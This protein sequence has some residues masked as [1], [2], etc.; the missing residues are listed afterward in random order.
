[1]T[2]KAFKHCMF[3]LRL[4]I[5]FYDQNLVR[6]KEDFEIKSDLF[7]QNTFIKIWKLKFIIIQFGSIRFW[8]ICVCFC[9][10]YKVFSV[11][12]T[13]SQSE[14]SSVNKEDFDIKFDL[15]WQFFFKIHWNSSLIQY[16]LGLY[17]FKHIFCCSCHVFHQNTPKAYF[18]LWTIYIR[19][20]RLYVNNQQDNNMLGH[21]KFNPSNVC[22]C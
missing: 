11:Y 19:L 6:K 4:Q 17:V 16:N 1:M 14:K 22:I 2:G 7:W 10:R 13:L 18:F 3:E 21:K 9:V 20:C 8:S 15:I 12:C 5:G